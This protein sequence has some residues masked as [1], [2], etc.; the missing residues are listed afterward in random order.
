MYTPSLYSLQQEKILNRFSRIL[1]R[2]R[3]NTC[4]RHVIHLNP[5]QNPLQKRTTCATE[6]LSLQQTFYAYIEHTQA[7]EELNLRSVKIML[8]RSFLT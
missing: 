6:L 3:L 5:F 1:S 8:T 2:T 4:E 7:N